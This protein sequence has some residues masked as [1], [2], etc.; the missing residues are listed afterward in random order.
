ISFDKVTLD[1]ATEYAAED[2][3]VTLRL[4]QRLKGRLATEAAT[5]V[6]ELVD[7]PLVPVLAAMETAG[8]KV[9]REELAR[10]SAEFGGEATRIEALIHAEAGTPFTVGSPKQLGDILFDRMGLKGGR[11]G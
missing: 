10:L 9:D 4:W 8:I 6:Y 7:R 5:R 11:K 2:A 1:R 3:D